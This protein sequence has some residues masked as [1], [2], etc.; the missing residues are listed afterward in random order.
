MK[1]TGTFAQSWHRL[2]A[3]SAL[4]PTI[5]SAATFQVTRLDDP[6]P[7]T[8]LPAD[9][10]LREAVLAANALPGRDIVRIG[11]G[12][13]RLEQPGIDEDAGLTGDIDITDDLD[14]IGEGSEISQI[15]PRQLDYVFDATRGAALT[16]RGIGFVRSASVSGLWSGGGIRAGFFGAGDEN[17]GR[18]TLEDVLIDVRVGNQR[19]GV[20]ARGQFHASRVTFRRADEWGIAAAFRGHDLRLDD[21][22]FRGNARALS[23]HLDPNGQ[24][25]I[26]DTRF[27]GNGDPSPC[28]VFSISGTGTTLLQ[29]ISFK[30]N[31]TFS[32]GTLC[33]R[34]GAHVVVR[35]STF[36]GSGD[37]VSIEPMGSTTASRVDLHNVTMSGHL[38]I[39][40]HTTGSEVNLHHSTLLGF[41]YAMQLYDGARLRATSSAIIGGCASQ[42]GAV[43]ESI[44]ANFE[45]P[46][47]TC[48]R[49]PSGSYAFSEKGALQLAVLQDNGGA[50]ETMLPHPDG[51]LTV[52]AAGAATWCPTTDQR[53]FIRPRPCTS[54][55]ADPLAVDDALLIDGLDY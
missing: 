4:L 31:S 27:I 40:V 19:V 33:I 28:N 35:D 29:R 2:L 32:G 8:C 25:R 6:V 20:L 48:F 26:T 10:S 16:V 49:W 24:A 17:L 38:P 1:R 11:A 47:R 22:E 14:V 42:S 30:N 43:F 21:V 15:D 44:G 50:T 7:D 34:G 45:A 41:T 18:L 52:M 13:H 36:A 39:A 9:C 55:A 51:P 5:G 12:I 37:L 3:I 53:G 23:F 54:G 46:N